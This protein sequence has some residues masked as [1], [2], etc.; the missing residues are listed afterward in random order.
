M[1]GAVFYHRLTATLAGYLPGATAEQGEGK[2]GS[3]LSCTPTRCRRSGESG[4][5][6]SLISLAACLDGVRNRTFQTVQ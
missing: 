5:G 6:L 4:P 3:D 1:E 2:E